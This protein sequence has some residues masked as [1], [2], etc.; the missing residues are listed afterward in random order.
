MIPARLE[1]ELRRIWSQVH[2]AALRLRLGQRWGHS[3]AGSG[4][5]QRI[6]PDYDTYLTHQRLVYE[7]E[8]VLA[9]VHRVL[10]PDGAFVAE[11]G[12]G[13]KRGAIRDSTK[14][15]RGSEPTS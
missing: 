12:S 14:R 2:K 11:L 6:Y 8:R 13:R 3:S 15:S 5:A 4:L 1:R 9:E 7:L 10:K